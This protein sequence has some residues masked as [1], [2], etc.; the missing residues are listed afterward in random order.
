MN[1]QDVVAKV[2]AMEQNVSDHSRRIDGLERALE[3]LE[4]E[5][6]AI[7]ELTASIQVI[8]TRINSIE[9]KVNDTNTKVNQQAELIQNVENRPYKQSYDRVLSIKQA[10]IIGVCSLIASGVVTAI[11]GL[12]GKQ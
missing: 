12:L 4:K 6:K 3:G 11:M 1:D 2:A 7:Y 10:L 9:E 8:A 5:Q